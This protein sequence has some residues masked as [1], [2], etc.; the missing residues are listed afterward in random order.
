M[1]TARALA[2][3][4]GHLNQKGTLNFKRLS[5]GLPWDE[6]KKEEEEE[7]DDECESTFTRSTLKRVAT[8][9]KCPSGYYLTCNM[10][11]SNGQQLK[12][13]VSTDE[14]KTV[15]HKGIDLDTVRFENSDGSP[16][17]LCEFINPGFLSIYGDHPMNKHNFFLPD[18]HIVIV[19]PVPVF[20]GTTCPKQSTGLEPLFRVVEVNTDEL[21]VIK[22]LDACGRSGKV[23]PSR[24]RRQTVWDLFGPPRVIGLR[25]LR[26]QLKFG[27]RKMPSYSFEWYKKY[28]DKWTPRFGTLRAAFTDP[29]RHDGRYQLGWDT[30][31]CEKVYERILRDLN[32]CRCIECT[33][34]AGVSDNPF[35]KDHVAAFRDA[36]LK[37]CY[38]HNQP[39]TPQPP[40]PQHTCLSSSCSTYRDCLGSGNYTQ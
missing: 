25:G 16:S 22:M 27:Q 4:L 19:D 10:Y 26:Y 18:H 24:H 32:V 14:L 33:P 31:G 21:K 40:P 1:A 28:G 17:R 2:T 34:V 13:W 39:G 30:P 8:I 5:D 12:S 9:R 37:L 20:I 11:A 23:F 7:K 29:D 38:Y 3:V 35:S 6:E 36:R 15:I